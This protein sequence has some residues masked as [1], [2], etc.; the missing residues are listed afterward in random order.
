M[1]TSSKSAFFHYTPEASH[2]QVK[3]AS[4]SVISPHFL[5]FVVW[6]KQAVLSSQKF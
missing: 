5:T 4:F 6:V 1:V 3:N 2:P